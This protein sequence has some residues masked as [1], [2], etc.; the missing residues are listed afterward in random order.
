[1]HTDGYA[2]FSLLAI[3]APRFE[4]A[5]TMYGAVPGVE[6]RRL[7]ARGGSGVHHFQ[8]WLHLVVFRS[9]NLTI[10]IHTN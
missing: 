10:D 5:R 6:D 7:V 9:Y 8:E 3:R 2:S 1:L 4:A